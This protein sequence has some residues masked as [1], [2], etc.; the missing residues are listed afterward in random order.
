MQ[1]AKVLATVGIVVFAVGM[2]LPAE[3]TETHRICMDG[4]QYCDDGNAMVVEQTQENDGKTPIMVSGAVVA[5]VGLALYFSP[6]E[7]I[8]EDWRDNYEEKPYER[9]EDE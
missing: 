9:I 6:D 7:D 2:M 1:T 4:T 5:L 3:T 8:R